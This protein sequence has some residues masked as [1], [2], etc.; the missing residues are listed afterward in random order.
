[1]GYINT[2]IE[3]YILDNI[4]NEG[5]SDAPLPHIDDKL[6]FLRETFLA[7]Y[8]WHAAQVGEFKALQ[9]WLA[10]L[11]SA[12]NVE[13]RNHLILKVGEQWG[14][15]NPVASEAQQDKLLN[16][17]LA[18]LAMGI[19]NMWKRYGITNRGDKVVIAVQ[20]A[21]MGRVAK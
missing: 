10:G 2:N 5:Y 1:M 20:N 19:Q 8:G 6:K 3:N 4:S 18:R 17:W 16:Q 12:I 14:L 15:I 9:S 13:H 11:P 7:E 21:L